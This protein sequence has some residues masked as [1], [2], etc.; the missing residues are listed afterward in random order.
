VQRER[1]IA[2]LIDGKKVLDVGSLGQSDIYCLWDTLAAH[3]AELMGVDLPN[4]AETSRDRLKVS[5]QGLE[6]ESD[7]RIRQGNMETIE[8]GE[9]FE[10]VVAGDVIEHTSNQGRLL[11]NIHHH[12]YPGGR[13][14]ITTPNAKWPTVFL[15]PNPTHVLWHDAH[16]LRQLLERH[17]FVVETLRYYFGNKPHYP[18]WQRPLL[19][20]QQLFVVARKS[21]P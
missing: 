12:L 19:V 20:R 4:A 16:T 14:I 8:L 11:D 5:P 7:P 15:R 9:C 6:H 10:V 17:D 2:A 1:L 13:L 3:S 18:L 21:A